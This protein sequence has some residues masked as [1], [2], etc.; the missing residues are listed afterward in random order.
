MTEPMFSPI[1]GMEITKEAW[2]HWATPVEER[3]IPRRYYTKEM[4]IKAIRRP[5]YVEVI[6][7]GDSPMTAIGVKAVI[8]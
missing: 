1:F 8:R 3:P 4:V 7:Y 6:R 2:E 5:N